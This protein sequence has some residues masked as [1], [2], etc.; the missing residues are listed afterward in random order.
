M[1]KTKKVSVRIGERHLEIEE[2]TTV[3]ELLSEQEASF[4]NVAVKVNNSVRMYSHEV[5]E[6]SVIELISVTTDEGMRIYRNSLV[7][8]LIVATKKVL[9]KSRIHIKHSLSNGIYGEIEFGRPLVEKDIKEIENM[10][11][12]LVDQNLPFERKKIP[13]EE[14][15]ELFRGQDLY[16]KVNLLK[17]SPHKE[18]TVYKCDDYYDYLSGITVP[19][20]GYLKTFKLRFYLP[21]FIIEFPKK[22]NPTV[23]APFVEQGKLANVYFKAE[24]WG[25]NIRV[26][27]AAELNAVILSGQIGNLIRVSE[28]YHEKQIAAIADRIALNK[29]RLRLILIAG[30]SSSGKTSFAQRLAT[31][32]RVNGLEPIAIG[33]DDYFLNREDTPKDEDGNYDFE[34]LEAIDIPLFNEHLSKLIQGEAIELPR[35]NFLTGRREWLGETLQVSEDQPIIIEGIHGLNDKLTSAIPKGRKFKIYISALTNLNIDDHIRIPTTDARLIRRMVRDNQFRSASIIDTLRRWPLVRRGEERHIFP[36]QE[37]ADVMFNSALDYELG[38][39]KRHIEPLLLEIDRSYPEYSEA[40]RL[41]RFLSHFQ[42]IEDEHLIPNNSII[43]EFIG[44]SCLF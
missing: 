15:I 17:F 33:L 14:G 42:P 38:V 23:V 32:L 6:N 21:G 20:T 30:P 26:T 31:Q 4:P 1:T 34:A 24:K 18:I 19:S 40:R 25:K 3:F 39:L 13:I 9:P 10:M 5:T 41:L 12:Q 16:D 37:D 36:F 44:G 2:G 43:R 7:F 22:H 28:A 29:D 8:L 27:N 35:F 11:Q